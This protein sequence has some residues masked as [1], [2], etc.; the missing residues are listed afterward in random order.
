VCSSDLHEYE[1]TGADVKDLQTGNMLS[2]S[3]QEDV[4]DLIKLLADNLPLGAVINVTTYGDVVFESELED[5]PTKLTRVHK[6]MWFSGQ[7]G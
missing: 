4:Q 7:L 5:E 2:E 3:A 1:F 6:D